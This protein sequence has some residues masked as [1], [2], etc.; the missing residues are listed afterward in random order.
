[1]KIK[2]EKLLIIGAGGHAVSCLEVILL[3]KKFSILGFTDN[4]IKNLNGFEVLGSDRD[5][6]KLRKKC[7]NIFIGLGS[8]NDIALRWLIYKRAKKIGF[9]FPLIISPRS[10]VSKFSSLNEGTIVMNNV[11]INSNAKI[12]KNC[13]INNKSLIEHDVK[14]GNNTHI[15]TGVIVNG[16]AKIGD[17]VFI[18]SGSVIRENVNI[19][20]NSIIGMGSIV[21]KNVNGGVFFKKK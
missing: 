10:H 17:N 11:I 5:I 18:G 21:L 19:K 9:N 12:G 6:H 2:K 13:I 1:M 8:V 15:A 16:G 7:K 20:S 3:E 14:I 4:K